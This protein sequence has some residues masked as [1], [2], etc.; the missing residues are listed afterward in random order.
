MPDR[1]SLSTEL[2]KS[3]EEPR[4]ALFKRRQRGSECLSGSGVEYASGAFQTVSRAYGLAVLPSLS[5]GAG[6]DRP[7]VQLRRVVSRVASEFGSSA[8]V[9]DVIRAVLQKQKQVANAS[10]RRRIAQRL[11]G[12]PARRSGAGDRVAEVAS[13]SGVVPRRFASEVPVEWLRQAS[14]AQVVAPQLRH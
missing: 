4:K 8:S 6:A 13:A 7:K 3:R 10:R 9:R 2:T 12:G 14:G 5:N 1:P 11:T